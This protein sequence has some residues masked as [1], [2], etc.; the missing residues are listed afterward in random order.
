M[1]DFLAGCHPEAE[2]ILPP[3]DEDHDHDSGMEP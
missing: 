3:P 2:A 1:M